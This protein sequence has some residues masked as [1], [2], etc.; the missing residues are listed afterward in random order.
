L[1][2]N[3]GYLVA[4][5][6][7]LG[8]NLSAMNPVSDSMTRYTSKLNE[9]VVGMSSKL[10]SFSGR[11]VVEWPVSEADQIVKFVRWQIIVAVLVVLLLSTLLAFY[12]A[13]RIVKPIKVLE[14]AASKVALGKLDQ[15]VTITTKDELEQ[16]GSAFNQMMDGLKRLAELKEEFVFVAS[17]ELRTP[18]TAIRW[19]LSMMASEKSGPL[20][21]EN[22]KILSQVTSAN[23]RLIQLVEDLLEVARNDAGRLTI[24][25][26]G[27]NLPEAV[28]S[29]LKE[30]QPLA[31][32]RQIEISYAV[33]NL[34]QVVANSDRVR[35]VLVNLVGNAIKYGKVGGKVTITHEVAETE[36][37]TNVADNGIGMSEEERTKLFEKFY[38][39][40]NSD[41]ESIQGT[42]LGL[43]IVKQI[44]EKMNGKIWVESEKGKGTIFSFSLK[45]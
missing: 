42:G 45:L 18:V 23:D 17:H 12:L 16:L 7:N 22:K 2:D 37:V 5:S 43:F 31:I 14:D 8:K 26:T 40:K 1:L 34:P 6:A 11:V 29:V 21:E 38:R 13:S 4:S 27:I 36:V 24:K 20:T 41:T 28:Q 25:L 15:H 10:S 35:E 30:L 3:K 32:E 44:V 9:E 19:Y 33:D 39:I